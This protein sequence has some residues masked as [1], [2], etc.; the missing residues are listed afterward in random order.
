MGRPRG[1]APTRQAEPWHPYPRESQRPT[2]PP[3]APWHDTRQRH[4]GPRRGSESRHLPRTTPPGII[5]LAFHGWRHDQN[6]P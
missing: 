4:P 5:G 3:V 1:L 2:G 6:K